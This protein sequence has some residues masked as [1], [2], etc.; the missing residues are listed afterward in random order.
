MKRYILKLAVL[1]LAVATFCSCGYDN[2]DEPESTLTGSIQ[3][4]GQKI[5]VQG[6]NG[7]VQLQLYQDG[8]QLHSPIAV[9][10]GQDG[11]FSSKLFDGTYKL[12][13]RD[14]NG[15][16]VNTRD[17]T[18]VKVSG[19]TEIVLEVTP[20]F[21]ISGATCSLSGNKLT[22]S[23]TIQQVVPTATLD[24]A[25]L[26]LSTTS[27]ADEQNNAFLAT[28]AGDQL[29]VGQNTITATLSDDQLKKASSAVKL[30]ARVGVRA[31]GAT[32]S[33]YSDVISLK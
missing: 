21:L 3:Y 11:T 16:W 12:V 19:H 13:T 9:M 6:T 30:I 32:Q 25:A 15:P 24:H 10:V 31:T 4:K 14:N 29:K 1:V 22:A 18:V 20:Y 8:Y 28:V 27:F 5:N 33:I 23:F 2:F 26:C 17:T 7:A